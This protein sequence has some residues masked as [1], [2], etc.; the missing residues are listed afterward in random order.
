MQIEREQDQER[1]EQDV[2]PRVDKYIL[3]I[4]SIFDVNK[5][6]L[7]IFFKRLGHLTFFTQL[8]GYPYKNP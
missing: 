7:N 1:G 5:G 8:L 4:S 6:S 3:E 2:F